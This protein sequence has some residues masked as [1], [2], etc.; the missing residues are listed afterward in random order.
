MIVVVALFNRKS[1]AVQRSAVLLQ[2][3]A[4]LE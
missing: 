1:G 2:F 3:Y 4:G